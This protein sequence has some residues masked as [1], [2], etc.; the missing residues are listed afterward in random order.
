MNEI[1]SMPSF[2]M[3]TREIQTRMDEVCSCS[4]KN[5]YIDNTRER[6]GQW[7][8]QHIYREGQQIKLQKH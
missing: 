7:Q 8:S 1:V 4:I 5:I 3:G 2:P 6:E